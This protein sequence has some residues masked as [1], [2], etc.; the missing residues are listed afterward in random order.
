MKIKFRI[1]YESN[2]GSFYGRFMVSF[3][4]IHGSSILFLDSNTIKDFPAKLPAI[5]EIEVELSKDF[6][7]SPGEYSINVAGFYNMEMADHIVNATILT[8]EQG[9]FF[10]KGIMPVSNSQCFV[11]QSW[12]VHEI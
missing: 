2:F 12:L 8:V 5:G 7:L 1:R 4:D 11:K 10:G 3:N 9:D 6:C